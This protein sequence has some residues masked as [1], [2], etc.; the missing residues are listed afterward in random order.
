M[1]FNTIFFTNIE[2]KV[3]IKNKSHFVTNKGKIFGMFNAFNVQ[4][5]E[6]LIKSNNTDR[7]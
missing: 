4:A 6:F 2:S 5:G 7:K 1:C 3:I